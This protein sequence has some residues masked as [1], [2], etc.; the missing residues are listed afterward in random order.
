MLAG[1]AIGVAAIVATTSVTDAVFR[2]F[3]RTV[4]LTAG[5][6]D[7]LVSNGEAGV[8]E[9]L[10][11]RV[12]RVNGVAGA[13]PFMSGSVSI[14]TEQRDTL[15]IFG[16][17]FLSDEEHEAQLP[18]SA[19]HIDDELL[20]VSKLDSVALERAFAE[21]HGFGPA[22][23]I[24]VVAPGGR[25][26][27]VVRGTVEA[28]G[29][30]ALYGGAVGLM[31][32]PAA[33]RLLGKEGRLDRI[34]VRFVQNAG[35]TAIEQLRAAVGND[36][37][38]EEVTS[39]GTRAKDMLFSLRVSLG[40]AGLIAVLVGFFIIFHT[41]S[42]ST[43][44][45]RRE[46]AL[47][48]AFGL[49]GLSIVVWLLVESS[50]L[51][52]VAAV[53]GVGLGGMLARTA[54]STF[55][56][57]TSAW[58]R[59]PA[60]Q[61]LLDREGA[62]FAVLMGALATGLATVASTWQLLVSPPARHLRLTPSPEDATGGARR[63]A[64]AAVAGFL[65]TAV[66]L[67]L[68]PQV[69][70]YGPLVAFVFAVNCLTLASFA[71]LAPTVSLLLGRSLAW[72]ATR[73][74]GLSIL[75]ASNNLAQN[76]GGPTAVVAAIVMGLGWSLAQ[77]SLTA[78]M[79]HSWL[80]WLDR[81]YSSDL[82]VSGGTGVSFLTSPPVADDVADTIR[83]IDGVAEVQGV[84]SLEVRIGDRSTVLLGVDPGS[85]EFPLVDGS[86]NSIHTQFWAWQG[87]LVTHNLLRRVQ[88]RVGSV[89]SLTT[90]SGELPLPVLGIFTDYQNGGD[91]GC[92]AVTRSLLK[93]R[94]RDSNLSR[95]SV[96]ASPNHSPQG[97]RS[98]IERRVRTRGLYVLTFKEA[99][100]AVSD[101][102]RSAFSISY[103]L[104]LIA[105]T[106]SF[107]GVFNFL[108]A[109]VLDRRYQLRALRALGVT[110]FQ[111]AMTVVS[112]GAL[113]GVV[114]ALVGIV[115][116]IVMSWIIVLHSVPMV[117]GWT[118]TWVM[119]PRT[120]AVLGICVVVLSA[121]AGLVPARAALHSAA[122]VPEA[123][124]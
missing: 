43:V 110:R 19:L 46:I 16:L 72:V 120:V 40:I 124:E 100:A 93:E 30:A 49:S 44:Q 67:A 58:V 28:Q 7:V 21:R 41:V 51:A 122:S 91:L 81:Y 33:Q 1:I 57:V 38:V 6:A 42:V 55:E 116:G 89:L 3:R 96:W 59:L 78:S 80:T 114:G 23:A 77:S 61:A 101:L 103:A 74:R 53:L 15:M 9:A 2:S 76:P 39:A 86:W 121:L 73:T 68:S 14:G 10:L 87:V 97:L 99:R 11:D 112:E 4:E 119:P 56:A 66:L 60:E 45:R 83:E 113:V 107:L 118:F 123:Q 47:L 65:S 64:L 108:L 48:S 98:E 20:F 82:V 32:L 52:T 13:A 111:I 102:V 117:N 22:S 95:L 26:T 37:V 25:R 105:L 109:A 36:G 50:A 92:I 69:L 75:L 54:V 17:D 63:A 88:Y 70:P 8:A 90:P 85:R 115:A 104:V 29:P 35:H 94:W 31:D 84:R 18:R 79:E 5:R 71:L 34:D 106:I 12:R 27:L 62:V 24:D